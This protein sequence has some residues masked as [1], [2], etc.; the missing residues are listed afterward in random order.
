MITKDIDLYCEH[1][2]LIENYEKAIQSDKMWVCHHRNEIELNMKMRDLIKAGLYYNRPPEE[3]IFLTQEEHCKLHHTGNNS[4][5]K[6]KTP[7]N[8]G[9]KGVQ[10]AWN[11]GKIIK[12]TCPLL[13]SYKRFVLNETITKICNDLD[14]SSGLVSKRLKE[15]QEYINK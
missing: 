15:I 13:L 8:K 14:V 4:P 5:N 9:K 11:K 1:P 2:E 10:A 12:F 6:G 3:F 7:W